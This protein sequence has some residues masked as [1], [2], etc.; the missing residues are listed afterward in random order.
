MEATLGITNVSFV[1]QTAEWIPPHLLAT[2]EAAYR[3]RGFAFVRVLQRC[4]VFTEDIYLPY[5]QDPGQVDLLEH[6]NGIVVPELESRYKHRLHHDPQDLDGARRLAA[7]DDRI[8]LGLFF[9]DESRPTYGDLRAL[10]VYTAEEK[11][12]R[13]NEELDR[14]AV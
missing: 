12:V 2:L 10:P 6:D 11:I 3:H 8:R 13:L 7:T 5:L 4:P 14:Y 1:A 9:R